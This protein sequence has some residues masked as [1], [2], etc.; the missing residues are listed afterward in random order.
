MF[1]GAGDGLIEPEVDFV[2][3]V[4]LAFGVDGDGG[5]NG[6]AIGLFDRLGLGAEFG[7]DPA[8]GAE[9]VD[10]RLVDQDVAIG[11]EEDPFFEPRFP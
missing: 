11:E 10:H 1:F 6:A 8:E 9:V 3:L 5:A 2:R 4:D 7:H